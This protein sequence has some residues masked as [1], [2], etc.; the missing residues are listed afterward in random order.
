MNIAG[1]V[2]AYLRAFIVIGILIGLAGGCAGTYLVRH[3]DVDLSV[4]WT[5]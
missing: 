4:R 3:V 5:P 2:D 1:A